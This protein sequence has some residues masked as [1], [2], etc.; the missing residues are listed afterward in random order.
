MHLNLQQPV[1]RAGFAPA[2]PDI[3]AE[4][5]GAVATGLGLRSGGEEITDVVEHAG[6]GGGVGPGGPADGALVDV[7]DLVQVFLPLDGLVLPRA[8][9]HPVQV[10]PQTLEE[11]FV[12]QGALSR[13]GHAGDA[14]EGPQ[15]NVHVDAP[16]VVL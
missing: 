3:E 11:N 13:P 7:D 10:R 4:P 9:L 12:D 5:S 8:A 14:G 15:G 16:Q 6:V 2:A 1:P